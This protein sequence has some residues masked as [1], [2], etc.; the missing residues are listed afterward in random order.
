MWVDLDCSYYSFH[1]Y[2][3]EYFETL[4]FYII[5]FLFFSDKLVLP[6][7]LQRAL[8]LI[9]GLPMRLSLMIP[10]N[11]KIIS[12]SKF[13]PGELIEI[14]VTTRVSVEEKKLRK[15]EYEYYDIIDCENILYAVLMYCTCQ[16][17]FF[18]S[19]LNQR[20]HPIIICQVLAKQY[21]VFCPQS[22][23]SSHY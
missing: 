19:V 11:D 17:V 23:T 14:Y 8:A 3:K 9:I 21:V 13:C 7:P 6:I 20:H 12:S 4:C 1:F 18:F 5:N 2:P 16:I 10:V 15:Y 22:N